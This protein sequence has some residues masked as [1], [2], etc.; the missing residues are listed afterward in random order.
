M[1]ILSQNQVWELKNTLHVAHFHITMVLSEEKLVQRC[2][3]YKC[4]RSIWDGLHYCT[5]ITLRAL[6]GDKP[7]LYES[8]LLELHLAMKHSSASH[9]FRIALR[10]EYSCSTSLCT[11]AEL[12]QCDKNIILKNPDNNQQSKARFWRS[13]TIP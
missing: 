6:P 9:C 13:S 1:L 8:L 10:W 12:I 3:C 11:A 4:T 7:W 5:S 2:P